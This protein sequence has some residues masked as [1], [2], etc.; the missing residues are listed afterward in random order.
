MR[1]NVLLYDKDNDIYTIVRSTN[2]LK[3]AEAVAESFNKLVH[4]DMILNIGYNYQEP[5]D[6]VYI[7]DTLYKENNLTYVEFKD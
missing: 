3:E 7:E 2:D 6:C 5:F 1:Y 4:R